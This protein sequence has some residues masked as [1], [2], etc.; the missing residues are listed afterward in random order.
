LVAYGDCG[1]GGKLDDVLREE[2]VERIEGPHC[3]AF[4][5]GNAAFAERAEGED[6]TAF[7]LTDYLAR[8]FD[9]LVFDYYR[10]ARPGMRDMMFGN[11]TKVVYLA[12]TDDPAIE[13]K[14]RAAAEQLGLAFEMRRTG[15]GELGDFLHRARPAP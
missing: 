4:F 11:Y 13:A 14:A 9:K 5:A 12:Q 3:Y 10:L 7:F 6:L 15:Y 8:H 2:G 1:T